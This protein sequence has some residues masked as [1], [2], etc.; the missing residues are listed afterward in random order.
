MG[1]CHPTEEGFRT[2]T[3]RGVKEALQAL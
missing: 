3:E 2:T 1:T